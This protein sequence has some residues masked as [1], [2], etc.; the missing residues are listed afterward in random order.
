MILVLLGT[1]NKPFDRLLK[2]ISKEIKNGNIK[3]KVVAQIGC[4]VYKDENIEMFDYRP[5]EEI[6]ELINKANIIITHGGVGTIIECIDLGKKIIVAPRLSKYKEH[7][8]N[9][10]LQITKEFA[11]KGYIIP[12]YKF[13]DLSDALHKAKKFKTK[14]YE[15]NNE[16]F[17]N[18]IKEYIDNF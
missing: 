4:T 13:S 10:Q 5:K 6:N 11:E 1:Q 15:S 8:N 7:T 2:A 16:N 17:R 18:K 9:H 3:D 14:K 12:L